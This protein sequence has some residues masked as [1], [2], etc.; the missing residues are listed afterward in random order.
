MYH[1]SQAN[2][3]LSIPWINTREVDLADELYFWWLIGI[4]ITA[5]HLQGVNSILMNTLKLEISTVLKWRIKAVSYM[6]RAEY[7]TIPV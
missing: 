5:V 7:C 4:L 2:T 3:D 6:R 1:N